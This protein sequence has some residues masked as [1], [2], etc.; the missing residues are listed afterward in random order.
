MKQRRIGI[1]KQGGRW[2]AYWTNGEEGFW[3]YDYNLSKLKSRL[4]KYD[5]V[6]F[7]ITE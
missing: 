3:M 2:A 4:R 1:D 5:C 7:I 6:P